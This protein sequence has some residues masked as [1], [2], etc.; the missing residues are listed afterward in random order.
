MILAASRENQQSAYAKKKTQISFPVTAKLISAFVFTTRVVQFIFFLNPKFQ[1]SSH[2]LRLHRPDCVGPVRKP[3]CW[4]SHEAAHLLTRLIHHHFSCIMRKPTMWFLTR[5]DTSLAVHAQ[6][7]ARGW[8][9]WIK[10]VEGLYY[11]F[12][13]NKCA[14]QLRSYCEA[15]LRLCFRMCEMLVFS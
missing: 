7:I 4:F 13:K 2:L 1:A 6:K 8:K 5:S 3:H 10:K 15:D 11:L 12:S 9:F 14:N